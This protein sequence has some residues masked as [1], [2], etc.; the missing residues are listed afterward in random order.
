MSE[1]KESGQRSFEAYNNAGANP[2]K[3]WDGKDVPEWRNLSDDVRAKWA[4][5]E[6]AAG[7]LR[8]EQ[9]PPVAHTATEKVRE[10]FDRAQGRYDDECLTHSAPLPTRILLECFEDELRRLD[11]PTA[12]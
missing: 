3:T 12:R 10:V 6:L 9:F 5:S 8:L 4:A 7:R 11:A 1:P 2:G